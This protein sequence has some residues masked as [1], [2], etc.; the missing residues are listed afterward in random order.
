MAPKLVASQL[1]NSFKPANMRLPVDGTRAWSVDFDFSADG[2][3]QGD[4]Q[5]LMASGDLDICQSV[6]IDNSQNAS[7]FVLTIKGVGIFGQRIIAQPYSQGYYPLSFQIGVMRY[8]AET[9]QG[10]VIPCIFYNICM[11]YFVWGPT[12]GVFIVPPLTNLSVAIAAPGDSVLVAGQLGKTIKLYRGIFNVDAATNLKFTDGAAGTNLF[13]L[14]YLAPGGGLT[15]QPSGIPWLTTSPGND[16]VLNSSA[17]A[18]IG[19]GFGY[20]QS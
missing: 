16:L 6:F 5:P 2:A 4:F 8:L 19:G 10:I 20:V 11:P 12:P 14:A 7:E 1:G 13:G 17:A 3:L 9:A 15:M 18:N